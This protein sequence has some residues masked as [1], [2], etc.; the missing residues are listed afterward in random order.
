MYVDNEIDKIEEILIAFA[1]H[2]SKSVSLVNLH[3]RQGSG[4]FVNKYHRVGIVIG[5]LEKKY[6][7]ILIKSPRILPMGLIQF[8]LS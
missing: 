8:L 1:S 3:A 4:T 7:Y 5:L 2:F 6:Y